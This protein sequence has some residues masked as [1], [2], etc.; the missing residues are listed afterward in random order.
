MCIWRDAAEGSQLSPDELS[1]TFVV[2][3]YAGHE[4]TT[5]LIGNG[6]LEFMRHPD[7]WRRLCLDPSLAQGAVAEVLRYNPPVQMIV[8]RAA[9]D[10]NLFG[11]ETEAGSNVMLLYGAAS[12]DPAVRPEGRRVGKE[13]DS[14][15]SVWWPPDQ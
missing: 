12:R 3:F 14:T 13:G 15:C 9:E 2:I 4:T 8:R 7:E 5:N 10:A 11:T 6:I 1:S